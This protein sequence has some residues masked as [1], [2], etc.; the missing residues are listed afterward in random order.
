[1]PRVSKF[2]AAQ[3]A[4]FVALAKEK[5]KEAAA[6]KAGV[7]TQ[8]IYLWSKGKKANGK[9]PKAAKANGVHPGGKD[10]AKM[11]AAFSKALAR[12]NKDLV[13]IEVI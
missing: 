13:K 3:K 10:A 2:S 7:S 4:E 9:A 1:M 12:L 5:G 8:T 6:K 11:I